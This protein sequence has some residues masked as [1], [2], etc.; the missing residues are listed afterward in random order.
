M[1]SLNFFI[2]ISL[3]EFK[4]RPQGGCWLLFKWFNHYFTEHVK[5]DYSWHILDIFSAPGYRFELIPYA[6]SQATEDT[7][8][9]HPKGLF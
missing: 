5:C 2:L 6:L 4:R 3:H 8:L 7:S 1:F 9:E